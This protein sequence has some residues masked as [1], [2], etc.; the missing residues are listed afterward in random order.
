MFALAIFVWEVI[1]ESIGTPPSGSLAFDPAYAIR[2]WIVVTIRQT[3]LLIV[4]AVT[5]L[6]VR[7]AQSVSFG[8]KHWML[9]A[10]TALLIITSTIV[11]GL[12]S[13]TGVNSLFYGLI[14]YSATIGVLSSIAFGY[15]VRTLFAIKKNLSSLITVDEAWPPVR[16][17][18]EK[19]R[20]SFA[21]EE[22]DAIRDGAS[23]LTSNGSSRRGSISTW[24]FSTHHTVTTSQHHGQG[25]PQKG[26]HSSSVPAKSSFWFGSTTPDDVQIP[27]VPPLPSPYGPVSPSLEDPDPF[28]RDLPPLPDHPRPRFGS[29][30]SWLTSSNGSHTTMTTWSYPATHHEGSVR[31]ASVQDFHTAYSPAATRPTTPALADAQVLGGYGYAP[32]GLEAE[33]GFASST[34]LAGTTLE[35]SLWPAIGWSVVIWLPLVSLV[36]FPL[37]TLR[38]LT[39]IFNLT[40]FFTALLDFF[41]TEFRTIYPFAD[42]AHVICNIVVSITGSESCPRLSFPHS[43]WPL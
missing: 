20:P 4:A 36:V 39:I 24:S 6:H 9:W 41:C 19:P 33:K 3:C 23:W 5:L 28:R 35:I 37:Q 2:L 30:S 26:T 14:A 7:M 32:G 31:A 16:E 43:C 25:R 40:E 11:A 17:M 8:A 38:I 27:P 18:E 29:Q 21:T 15:L 34:A 10:P 1:D 42:I 13:G 12:L 22:I